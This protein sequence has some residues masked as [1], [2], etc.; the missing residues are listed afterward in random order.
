MTPH[1]KS[2]YKIFSLHIKSDKLDKHSLMLICI[3]YVVII[4]L[5]IINRGLYVN[6]NYVIRFVSDRRAD[7]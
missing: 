2:V 6:N 7:L 4:D 1:R 3:I 5:Y